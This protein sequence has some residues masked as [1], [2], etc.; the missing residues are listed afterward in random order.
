MAMATGVCAGFVT[1]FLQ[2]RMG[3]PS[4]LAGIITNFGLYTIN[5]MIMGGASSVNLLKTETVFSM[6]RKTGI[7]GAY[8]DM[9][10]V[11]I[12][13]FIAAVILLWFLSTRLGLSIRATG[14]NADMVRASS[15]NPRFTT[16]V[17]LC[18][19]NSLTAL[20]GALVSQYNSTVDINSGTGIVVIALACLIIGETL[21]GKKTMTKGIIA[22]FVGSV[23][24]RIIYAIVLYTRIVPIQ[25]LKLITALVV[26][27]AI[28]YP[29]LK[30]YFMFLYKKHKASKKLEEEGKTNA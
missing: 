15:V 14:D 30:E 13:T 28:A 9:V 20:S 1:A 6:F 27:L 21:L 7:F 11:A 16:T 19:A 4:I 5:L 10:L 22:A 2:T 29:T 8:S 25:W 24:Y 17:A 3:V 18:V 12:I 23:V 26:A